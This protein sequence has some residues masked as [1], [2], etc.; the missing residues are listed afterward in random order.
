M[1]PRVHLPFGLFPLPWLLV[2]GTLLCCMPPP[3]LTLAH[4]HGRSAAC[5]HVISSAAPAHGRSAACQ[6]QSVE[7]Y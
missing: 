6:H 1:R 4:Q 2:P 7:L 5:Q 3:L